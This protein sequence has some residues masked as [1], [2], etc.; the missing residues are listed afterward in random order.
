MTKHVY[1][2]T[3]LDEHW[4]SKETFITE[5][6]YDFA[7]FALNEGRTMCHVFERLVFDLPSHL[8]DQFIGLNKSTRYVSD[9]YLCTEE[10]SHDSV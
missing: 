2:I 10:P 7:L 1:S 5:K 3:W 8:T 4:K 6:D 9:P